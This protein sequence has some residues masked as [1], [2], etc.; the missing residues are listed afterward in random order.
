MTQTR[1]AL[2]DADSMVYIIS[3]NNR[4]HKDEDQVKASVDAFIESVMT[5]SGSQYYIGSFSAS[6]S[7]RNEVYKY[8]VYKGSR[9]EKPEWF[10]HWEPVI[11]QYA[12]EKWNFLIPAPGL[13]ADDIIS[14]LSE[15]YRS[16][17]V[18]YIILSPDKD[19]RQIPGNHY[20][21][22][23]NEHVFVTQDEAQMNFWMQM[24]TGDSTDN[25]AGVPGLGPIKAK[26]AMA[27]L[28]EGAFHSQIVMKEYRKY[29]G[30]YYGPI[31]FQE[32]MDTLRLIC[33][34]HSNWWVYEH[35][36]SGLPKTYEREFIPGTQRKTMQEFFGDD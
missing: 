17:G 29:F 25:V 21:Y 14:A 8:A 36:L 15:I 1:T 6:P 23:K 11:K 28:E 20:D 10:V 5:M 19:L 3:Y 32:T 2:I 16:E 24:L 4:E 33:K 18:D 22:G 12:Q 27:A 13:E 30:D 35:Y 9:P 7:F 34:K 31:I 26:K